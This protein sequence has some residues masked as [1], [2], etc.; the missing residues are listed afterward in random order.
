MKKKLVLGLVVGGVLALATPSFAITFLCILAAAAFAA[1]LVNPIPG[2][3]M[4]ILTAVMIAC[5]G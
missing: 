4:L 5:E 1:A 2:D 3:E